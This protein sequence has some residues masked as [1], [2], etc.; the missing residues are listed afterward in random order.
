MCVINNYIVTNH[1]QF[2]Y[3]VVC[4]SILNVNCF[5]CSSEGQPYN[6]A[7]IRDNKQ[8]VFYLIQN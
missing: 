8:L 1:D 4:H 5:L 7:M 2:V 6:T 3:C